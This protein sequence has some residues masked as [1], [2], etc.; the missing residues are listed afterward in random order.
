MQKT[1]TR[2]FIIYLVLFSSVNAGAQGCSCWQTRDTSFHIAQFQTA[3]PPF[4]RIDDGSTPAIN[5]PFT[6]CFWGQPETQ[7]YINTNGNITFGAGYLTFSSSPFP[8]N[9]GGIGMIA[10]FWA[11]VDNLNPPNYGYLGSDEVYYKVTP[12]YVVIQWDTIGYVGPNWTG[13][14]GSGDYGDDSLH[15]SFQV[16][17]SNGTDPIIPNGNNVEFCYKEMQWTTGA[18]SPWPCAD[19]GKGFLGIP[20]TVGANYGDGVKFVQIGR[21]GSASSNYAGQYPPGPNY[22]GVYWLDNK[23]FEFNLCSG[24]IAPLNSGITPCDTFRVCVGDSVTIPFYFFTPIQGDSVWVKLAPPVPAGVTVVSNNPGNTDSVILKFV[25]SP[26]SY[27]FHRV[28][29]YGYDNQSPPDTSFA[30]FV[31]EVDSAPRYH[32]T[33]SKDTICKGDSTTLTASGVQNYYW[34]TGATTSSI[35]VS[36]PTTQ[37]YTLGLSN[38]KCVKD[39]SVTITVLQK[40]VPTIRVVKDTLCPKDS[41]L[42]IAG[43]GGPYK[44]STGQTTDSIWVKPSSD[45]T[46]NLVIVNRCATDTVKKKVYAIRV[47][48]VTVSVSKDSICQGDSTKLTASGGGTYLWTTGS[49]SSAITVTPSG[50]TTY[51]LVTTFNGKCSVDTTINIAVTPYPVVTVNSGNICA[52]QCVQLTASSSGPNNYLWS[53]G[54]TTDTITVCPGTTTTYTVNVSRNKC[55][56]KKN[57]TVVVNAG[58]LVTACCNQTI[59]N[60]TTVQLTA[61]GVTTY[62]WLPNSGLNCDTCATVMAT[63]SITTTYT[64]IG[65]DKNGCKSEQEVTVDVACNDFVVPNIFTPNNDG[66]NDVFLIP[67]QYMSK[68]SVTI[69]DRWGNK[70]FTSTDANK[71]W[72]GVNSSG[73]WVSNGTYYY[74]ITAECS[75][76]VS[77]NKKGFVQLLR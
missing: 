58:A 71:S 7:V 1:I 18:D 73:E 16:I 55:I 72:T 54:A 69:Y 39:T 2:F 13:C 37:T 26:L 27:G 60:G 19:A 4:Y 30:S 46:Y 52:G 22:D 44:W 61:S 3:S 53:T 47:G 70:V 57:T 14:G 15:N 51:T 75:S 5:L 62:Q 23:S 29:L 34:S 43:G 76:G 6:F 49:T 67:A 32:V 25:G 64:V 68:F 42:L 20:A 33:I 74:M 36:P 9:T 35:K 11:D 77:Y 17:I 24:Q 65:T 59:E 41:S 12:N 21:F 63:P 31:I 48:R 8:L 56:T 28:N 45:S 66:I 50:N 40:P 38:G 10:P